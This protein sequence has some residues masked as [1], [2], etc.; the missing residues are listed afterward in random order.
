MLK[1]LILMVAAVITVL[2]VRSIIREVGLQFPTS[3]TLVKSSPSID[4]RETVAVRFIL[5]LMVLFA[6]L[7]TTAVL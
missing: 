1:I 7:L 3:Y 6:L 4:R 2:M 5:V